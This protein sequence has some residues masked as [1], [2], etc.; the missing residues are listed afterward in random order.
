MRFANIGTVAVALLVLTG[1][2]NA[3]LLIG[4]DRL[5]MLWTSLYGQLLLIKLALFAVMLALAATNRFRLTPA[6]GRILAS[7]D[8]SRRV[9]DLRI[10]LAAES[11]A[12]IAILALVAWLGALSPP[13]SA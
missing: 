3:G 13:V 7:A 2:I 12:A 1:L 11:A 6:L 8:P 5:P 9:G 10:S 4:I